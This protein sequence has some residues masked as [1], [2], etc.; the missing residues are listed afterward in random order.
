MYIHSQQ[1]IL[2]YH[3][4]YFRSFRFNPPIFGLN[5]GHLDPQFFFL[6][7]CDVDD[8]KNDALLVKFQ[9]LLWQIQSR[10]C[11]L[12]RIR[13]LLHLKSRLL[14]NQIILSSFFPELALFSWFISKVLLVATAP[15]A[16]H[17]PVLSA[18]RGVSCMAQAAAWC[19][20]R[21]GD[22]G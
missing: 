14:L 5:F 10:F 3:W 11:C 1:K 16:H 7:E 15:L 12:N 22:A 9:L 19:R 20:C 21:G 8:I 18:D 4:S 17:I 13:S 6:P 2:L